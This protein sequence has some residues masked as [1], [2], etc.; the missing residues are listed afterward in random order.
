MSGGKKLKIILITIPVVMLL[1]PVLA[2]KLGGAIAGMALC[3]ILFFAVNPLAVLC[4]GILSGT[5]IR[6]LFWVP[7]VSA[8]AFP[9]GFSVAVGELVT[10]LFVYAGLYVII[11]LVA[12]GATALGIRYKNSRK[13]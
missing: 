4:L 11:G 1:L 5:D 10:D 2:L 9:L 6:H 8:L 7:F 13:V 3:F 12:M